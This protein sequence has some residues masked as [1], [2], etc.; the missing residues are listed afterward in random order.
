MNRAECTTKASATY[1]HSPSLKLR[2][3][4]VEFNTPRSSITCLDHA[5][6]SVH[7]AR[8]RGSVHEEHRR[9]SVRSDNEGGAGRT[10][11]AGGLRS[12]LRLAPVALRT[13]DHG[14]AVPLALVR[15]SRLPT[16]CGRPMRESV[17]SRWSASIVGHPF[18]GDRYVEMTPPPI[19]RQIRCA[20]AIE[21]GQVLAARTTPASVRASLRPPGSSRH[22]SA[23]R[24]RSRCS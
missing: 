12:T 2:R 13:V 4:T 24:G 23:P 7:R 17:H 19:R 16:R 15:D 6:R 22:R 21:V 20:V 8:S 5:R 10:A 11:S 14:V 1:D 18:T 9:G 3:A